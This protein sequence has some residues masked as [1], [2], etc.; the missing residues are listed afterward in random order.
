MWSQKRSAWTSIVLLLLITIGASFLRLR[1]L[2]TVPGWYPDEG[3]NIAIAASLAQGES[4]YLAFGH[5]SFINGHPPL[6][7]FLMAFLF[8]CFGVDILWARLLTVSLGLLT[9][10]LLYSVAD[11]MS[12]RQVALLAA[13]F[14]ALYPSAVV[15]SRLALTYNLLA[16]FYL[17]TLYGLWRAAEDG[18]RRWIVLAVL[19]TGAALLTDL[20]AVS[21]LGFLILALV[22]VRP[23]ALWWALPL[24]LFPLLAWGSVMGLVVGES[25]LQ[26][27]AFTL[28]RAT[29]SLPVQ[30]TSVVFYR[31][32]LEGDPWLALGGLALLLQAHRQRWLA[33]GLFGLSLLVFVRNGPAFGQSSYFL[34][35]LFP[36]AAWGVGILLA[37]GVPILTA[38]LEQAWRSGLAR[39]RLAPRWRARLATLLTGLILFLLVLAPLVSMLAEGLWLDYGL[40]LARFGD[41]L[42][43]PIA[44]EQAANYV[45]RHTTE[46]DVVLASP[47]IVWL[48]RAHA[49]DFQMA[50]AATGRATQ[51]FPANIPACRFR[52]DPRLGNAAYVI[53]DPLWR[54]WASTRMPEVAVMVHEVETGWVLEARLGEFEVY[55]HP[56]DT[57][58]G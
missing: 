28:S 33:V 4:A 23:R 22:F 42:A 47:A 34:I 40:Y 20:A 27:V 18:R 7:Y 25:F 30:V 44:A 54:G 11:R 1:H 2:R 9:L 37:R 56:F 55:R 6:A 8:R 17:L 57:P 12:G 43:N 48:L 53:L 58:D 41:T 45:N 31:T 21:L 32:T 10:V 16:P 50:V 29:A 24:A 19:C 49:A 15:Y 38:Q 35:P 52:F 51:H 13:A 39:L 26:D 3:S 36:L 5:S 46:D 14:Y